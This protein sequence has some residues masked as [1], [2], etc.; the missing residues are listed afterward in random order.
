M[1]EAGLL[2]PGIL[3]RN[4]SIGVDLLDH[5]PDALPHRQVG[6]DIHHTTLIGERRALQHT[7]LLQQRC[8][9]CCPGK[10]L[11]GCALAVSSDERCDDGSAITTPVHNAPIRAIQ[12]PFVRSRRNNSTMHNPHYRDFDSWR[13]LYSNEHFHG[14]IWHSVRTIAHF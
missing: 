1:T 3:L 5:S 11:I 10:A 4:A 8:L 9:S 2:Q 13:N 14:N 12:K 7:H 6:E